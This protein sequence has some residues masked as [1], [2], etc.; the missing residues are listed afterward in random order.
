[1]RER[2]RDKEEERCVEETVA[3]LFVPFARSFVR[4][5]SG[6]E[7]TVDMATPRPAARIPAPA[8]H[9]RPS[10]VQ[11][12]TPLLRR[13]QR[14]GGGAPE[15]HAHAA[16]RGERPH[17]LHTCEH[18]A[19]DTDEN[20]G[21]ARRKRM[22]RRRRRR[23]VAAAAEEREREEVERHGVRPVGCPRSSVPRTRPAPKLPMHLPLARGFLP[24]LR[25][26]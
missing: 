1:M 2:A 11:P 17:A 6:D 12:A 19:G 22:K 24:F 8:S 9:R 16:R 25:K 21:D 14:G 10:D 18:T 7:G 23:R 13:Q 15:A 20:E 3:R 5:F 26:K 4:S